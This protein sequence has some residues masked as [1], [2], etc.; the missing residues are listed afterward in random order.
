MEF[1]IKSVDIDGQK[2]LEPVFI[3]EPDVLTLML[4]ISENK[5][6]RLFLDNLFKIREYVLNKKEILQYEILKDVPNEYENEL[7]QYLRED[8]GFSLGNLIL[9]QNFVHELYLYYRIETD[10][11][12]LLQYKPG[13]STSLKLIQSSSFIE[14]CEKWIESYNRFDDC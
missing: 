2:K 13:Y 11:V 4:R 9:L 1:I 7:P 12:A 14:I 10:E 5:L 3:N 8:T 6:D